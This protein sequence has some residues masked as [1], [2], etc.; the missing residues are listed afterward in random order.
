MRTRYL[1]AATIIG[2]CALMFS[3]VSQAADISEVDFNA[4][5]ELVRKQGEEM[6]KLADEVHKLQQDHSADKAG[7]QRTRAGQDPREDHERRPAD[8]V[9]EVADRDGQQEHERDVDDDQADKPL[10]GQMERLLDVGRERAECRGVELVE[11]VEE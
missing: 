1:A 10:V 4:L 5:K 2:F 9:G 7:R 8:P 3:A 6:Q 11:E